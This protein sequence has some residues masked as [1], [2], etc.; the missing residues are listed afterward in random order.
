MKKQ[1][2]ENAYD[3]NSL[4]LNDN[5]KSELLSIAKSAHLIS[6]F[7]MVWT[8]LLFVILLNLLS[9][10]VLQGNFKTFRP[11]SL[12]FAVGFIFSMLLYQFGESAKDAIT[13][14]KTPLL[15]KSFKKL[16]WIAVLTGVGATLVVSLYAVLIVA[17]WLKMI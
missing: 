5:A 14:Q 17:S 15:T 2:L 7:G 16:K 8:L 3:N 13:E 1:I 9:T 11:C 10:N 6:V 12:L 4:P